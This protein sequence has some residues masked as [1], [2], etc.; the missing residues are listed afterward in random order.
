MRSSVRG[1]DRLWCGV[2]VAALLSVTLTAC[3]S[4]GGKSQEGVSPAERPYLLPPY[5]GWSAPL[6]PAAGRDLQRLYDALIDDNDQLQALNGALELLE[7]DPGLGPARVLEAQVRHLAGRQAMALERLAP[8][9]AADPGY[10][11]AAVLYGRVAEQMGRPVDAFAA[12]YAVRAE[13][14]VAARRAAQL[15]ETVVAELAVRFGE[16]LAAGRQEAAS[17]TLAKLRAWAPEADATLAAADAFG[18]VT[19]DPR[20]QLLRLRQLPGSSGGEPELTRRRA[21]LEIEVGDPAV[22]VRLAEHLLTERP[23]DLYATHLLERARF[24]WR[25]NLLPNEVRSLARRPELNRSEFAVLLYWLFPQVRYGR[26]AE[27]R[28]ATDVI[29]HPQREAIVRVINLGLLEVDPTVHRFEPDSS[30]RRTDGLEALLRL[31]S[32]DPEG[33]DCLD[34]GRVPVAPEYVCRAA[35]SCRLVAD[36][37][38]CVPGAPL[39]GAE[40]MEL[41]R[42]TLLRLGDE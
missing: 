25:F 2:G 9:V 19:A 12:Y 42:R 6:S 39:S 34:D 8:L 21:D 13:A 1:R 33:A 37:G 18:G 14:G 35:V 26:P 22:A 36:E 23:H 31:I 4:V 30:L 29:D 11:S 27:A 28:I 16:Q 38:E 17:E 10:V 20:E 3:I 24:Q 7:R 41:G 15:L 5:E 32:R 40:G